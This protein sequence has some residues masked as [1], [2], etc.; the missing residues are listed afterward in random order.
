MLVRSDVPQVMTPLVPLKAAIA[1]VH[2][3]KTDAAVINAVMSHQVTFEKWQTTIKPLE[4]Q[5]DV[6]AVNDIIQLVD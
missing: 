2:T 5:L 4:E 3:A 6:T 1:S